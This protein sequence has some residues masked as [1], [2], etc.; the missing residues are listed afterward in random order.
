M[1]EASAK[2][3]GMRKD[4]E[5]SMEFRGNVTPGNFFSSHEVEVHQ[6]CQES[7]R[8]QENSEV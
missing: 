2:S 5:T 7:R 1:Q 3:R 4:A 8:R 6:E